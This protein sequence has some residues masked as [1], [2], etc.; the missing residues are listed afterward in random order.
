MKKSAS[1]KCCATCCFWNG[2]TKF[3]AGGTFSSPQVEFNPEE[4][5]KCNKSNW[6]RSKVCKGTDG[7]GLILSC[8][9][10]KQRYN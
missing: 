1:E 3:H 9:N 4:V 6:L 8:H 5:A 2:G 7:G 10:W